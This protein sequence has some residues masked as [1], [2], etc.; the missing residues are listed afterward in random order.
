[1]EIDLHC[2]DIEE[3]IAITKQRIV[4][5]AET[6]D[7]HQHA[8]LALLCAKDHFVNV[9]VQGYGS[10]SDGN[11]EFMHDINEYEPRSTLK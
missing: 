3:A 6:L 1:M 4:D 8:V 2:L 11:T 10:D 9:E 7:Q 5:L